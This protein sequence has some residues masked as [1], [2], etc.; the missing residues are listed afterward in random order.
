MKI[1]VYFSNRGIQAMVGKEDKKRF[2]ISQIYHLDMDEGNI[3]NGVITSEDGLKEAIQKFWDRYNLPKKQVEIIISGA[4]SMTKVIEVPKMNQEKTMDMVKREFSEL[5]NPEEYYFDYQL[6]NNDKKSGVIPV[7]GVAAPKNIVESYL[8]LF[9]DLGI[10]VSGMDIS[11][12]TGIKLWEGIY[13]QIGVS[14]FIVLDLDGNKLTKDLYVNGRFVTASQNR[15]FSFDGTNEFVDE[16]IQAVSMVQQFNATLRNDKEINT[17][18]LG[19]FTREN[20]QITKAALSRIGVQVV[21]VSM[22]SVATVPKDAYVYLEQNNK[23]SLGLCDFTFVAGAFLKVKKKVNFKK[24]YAKTKT[25][26]KDQLLKEYRPMMYI[27][28]VGALIALVL[29]AINAMI[30]MDINGT[31]KWIEETQADSAY[32]KTKAQLE[33]N[34]VAQAQLSDAVA[35]ETMINSYPKPSQKMLTEIVILFG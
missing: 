6:T 18:F 8:N 11:L 35:M 4:Q 24:I 7:L 30:Y 19:G 12:S 34:A 33:E 32:Q 20:H 15:I 23:D 5:E 26:K 10:E 3:L 2:T 16:M 17:V 27:A 22:E 1:A 25:T 28:G 31:T 21:E 29:L 14:D 9:W 13:S